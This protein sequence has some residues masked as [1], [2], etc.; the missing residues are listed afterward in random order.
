[1]DGEK[2]NR[3]G[4]RLYDFFYFFLFIFLFMLNIC[5]QNVEQF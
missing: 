5:I 4:P 1:M 2:T 3:Q